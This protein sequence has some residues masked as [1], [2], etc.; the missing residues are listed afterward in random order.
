MYF[1]NDSFLQELKDKL[2]NKTPF[3]FS[4]WADGEW[5]TISKE[6]P[7]DS[8]C[9]GNYYYL[10]LADK[11]ISIITEKQ[12]TVYMGHQN[13]AHAYSLRD[14]YPQDW[15]NSDLLH[16]LSEERGLDDVF[17]MF[18]YQH[19]VYIG[20]ES[21]SKLSFID[22]FIEIPYNNVWLKYEEV[23]S[24]IKSKMVDDEYKVFLFSGGMASNAFIHDLWEYNNKNVYM[25]VGSAFDP[26]VGRNSRSY[27]HKLNL[28][29]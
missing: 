25:D 10:D 2:N 28:D 26:Y 27:H 9:D 3:A 21:L 11:L 20:N 7:S 8:N 14:K 4:R 12:D 29:I 22:E 5:L 1:N 17:E 15:V 19:I 13:V 18:S 24:E 23:M 6:N 16:E